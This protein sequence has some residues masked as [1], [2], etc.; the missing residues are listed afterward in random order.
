LSSLELYAIVPVMKNN[1]VPPN[2]LIL[3]QKAHEVTLEEIDSGEIDVAIEKM[4]GVGYGEQ[5]DVQKPVLVGLAAPQ[6]GIDKRIILVDIAAEGRGNTGSLN[7]YLNPEVIWQSEE[8]NEWYEGCYSTDR[9]CGI[10]SRPT[11]VK[12]KALNRKGK[13]VEEAYEGYTARIF[14]HEID[15]LNGKVFIDHIIDDDKLHWV[16]KDEFPQYRD[17]QEWRTWPHKCSRQKWEALKS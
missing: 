7:V 15:H 2:S 14:Q 4:F 11:K 10:V 17:K 13:S 8:E 9:V 6:I 1:F 16:E 5:E 3:I 12:I